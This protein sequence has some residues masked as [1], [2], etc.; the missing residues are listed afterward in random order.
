MKN[1]PKSVL[2]T[3]VA[4]LILLL[5]GDLYNS[6]GFLVCAVGGLTLLAAW[7]LALRHFSKSRSEKI[8]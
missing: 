3:A 6:F 5:A 4:G 2:I 8:K 1:L 7:L